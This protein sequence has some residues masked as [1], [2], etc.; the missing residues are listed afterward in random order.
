MDKSGARAFVYAKACGMI[1][2]SFT[3]ERAN[4][5]FEVKSLS[6]L[7]TLLFKTPVP[8][9]P[10]V[11]LAQ[12]IEEEAFNQFISQYVNL[13]GQFDKPDSFLNDQLFIYEVQNLKEIGD[14]L[15]A[16][17]TKMPSVYNLGKYSTLHY[18]Q[19]PD[20]AKITAGTEFAWFNKLPGIHEQQ[21][22]EYRLDI[23]AVKHMWE[24]LGKVSG[25]AGDALKAMI[26]EELDVQ[27]VVWALRLKL[28]YKMT[29]EE[30]IPKLMYVTD[31]PSASDPLCSNAIKVLGKNP[32]NYAEWE[33]WIYNSYVNPRNENLWQ[34]DPAWI[35]KKAKIEQNKKALRLFHCYPLTSVSLLGWFKAKQF[36][37]SCVRMAVEGIRLN[38]KP[39]LEV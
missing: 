14:A 38:E 5:L 31:K 30:I 12:Q 37:L 39:V 32:E 28:N 21:Q 4:Q 19:W 29:D 11:M 24:S 26:R 8:M 1:G 2:K 27:N 3:G 35:E 33:N 16:G 17:E 6:E 9:V 18:D 25:E 20:I 7:W 23:Q 13:V 36:E 34:I 10:E 15:C 22:V